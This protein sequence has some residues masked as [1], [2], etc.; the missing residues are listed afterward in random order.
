[1]KGMIAM[2]FSLGGFLV[3]LGVAYFFYSPL[4]DRLQAYVSADLRY[5]C[6]LSFILLWILT[7]VGMSLIGKLLTKLMSA[8]QLGFLNRLGG[9]TIGFTKVY[10]VLTVLVVLCS[11]VN[12]FRTARTE[13][14]ACSFMESSA[15]KAKTQIKNLPISSWA[16]SDNQQSHPEGCENE[17]NE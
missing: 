2:L 14:K 13:S 5:V 15:N 10:C 3:G 1:M 7:M 4:A 11:Y 9:A 6:I 8:L 16:S 12:I 17:N